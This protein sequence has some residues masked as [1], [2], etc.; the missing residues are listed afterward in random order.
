MVINM[1][2]E[3]AIRSLEDTLALYTDTSDLLAQ[4][5][6]SKKELDPK[7]KTN[8]L[9]IKKLLTGH[10]DEL[11]NNDKTLSY[12]SLSGLVSSGAISTAIL[13]PDPSVI[14]CALI[15]SIIFGTASYVLGIKARDS[16]KLKRSMKSKDPKKRAYYVNRVLDFM[17][18]HDPKSNPVFDNPYTLAYALWFSEKGRELRY[19]SYRNKPK[20][21]AYLKL[22]GQVDFSNFKEDPLYLFYVALARDMNN[23]VLDKQVIPQIA[24]T[25]SELIMFEKYKM[26]IQSRE[27]STSSGKYYIST[28]DRELQNAVATR[29][30]KQKDS[31]EMTAYAA[32]LAEQRRQVTENLNLEGLDSNG[33]LIVSKDAQYPAA[34]IGIQDYSEDL[35]ILKDV[36]DNWL[37]T[38]SD[39]IQI[40]K[41]PMFADMR[42]PLVRDFHTQ[43]SISKSL[44]KRT[45]GNDFMIAVSSLKTSWDSLE[46]EARRVELLNFNEGER[47]KILMAT[48]LMNIAL[49]EASSPPERQSAYKKAME[50]LKGL[51]TIPHRAMQVVEQAVRKEEL[52]A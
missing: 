48:N 44:S 22:F 29:M 24:Q 46:C 1:N 25:D 27:L 8:Y 52:V 40:L 43:L 3:I 51:L 32:K 20:Y 49:N 30:K 12:S 45:L 18:L 15:G 26:I 36:E 17:I 47:K 37:D 13:G 14:I 42:E 16:I 6:K 10:S 31:E 38:Q 9:A 2:N 34:G 50:Q 35:R 4:T 21:T 39:I 23:G 33:N 19:H 7:A 41:Y 28:H 11:Y 5:A